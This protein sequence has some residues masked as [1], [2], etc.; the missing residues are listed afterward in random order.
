MTRPLQRGS[1]TSRALEN[2]W[3]HNENPLMF[4]T[5]G[6]EAGNCEGHGKTSVLV[7]CSIQ[8]LTHKQPQKG[9]ENGFRNSSR[10]QER[11]ATAVLCTLKSIFRSY[12][13]DQSLFSHFSDISFLR[14]RASNPI[15]SLCFSSPI[16]NKRGLS[17]SFGKISMVAFVSIFVLI[18]VLGSSSG[19]YSANTGPILPYVSY[20]RFQQALSRD[21]S[22]DGI[23]GV[24]TLQPKELMACSKDMEHHVP[25]Y[26]VSCARKAGLKAGEEF[27]RHCELSG[28]RKQC[29]IRPPKDYRLPVRWPHSKAAIWGGNVKVARDH[30]LA[31][32]SRR[33]RLMLGE[34]NMISFQ[35]QD[36]EAHFQQIAAIIGVQND[37]SFSRTGIKAVLD[38][39]CSFG[40]FITYLLSKN[41]LALCIAPYEAHNSQVQL[42][43]ERGLPAMIGSVI[44][45]QLPYPVSSFNM[46]QCAEC[47][48]NWSQKD[49]LL[50]MEIDRL[51]SQ[52]G[53]FVWSPPKRIEGKSLRSIDSEVQWKSIDEAA[54]NMCWTSFPKQDQVFVWRKAADR[55]CYETRAMDAMSNI[56]N[57]DKDSSLVAY[58]PLRPCLV[59]SLNGGL[60]SAEQQTFRPDIPLS[61]YGGFSTEELADDAGIWSS[62]V[63]NYWSLITPLIFSDHPKRPAEDDPLP[64]Y[65]I[66]RNVMDMNA[67]YGGF[68][69]AL[70]Q[71]GKSAW[72]MNV[73]PTTGRNT[74][75]IIYKRGFVGALHNWCEAFPTYPR[76][77]DLLHGVGLISQQV[78]TGCSLSNLFLEMDRILRP[79]GWVLLR[80]NTDLIEE[81]RVAASQMRWEARVTEV[82]GDSDLRLLV[83]QKI[84][85]KP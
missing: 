51:L 70:L 36:A 28:G 23:F 8:V 10:I 7:P 69:A 15:P 20:R 73:V 49:G 76:T 25:C 24:D 53:Y 44:T 66:L 46:I 4:Q 65:N 50:L 81:A 42:A 39:G 67:L 35:P 31:K 11:N 19:S 17:L 63:R 13:G 48:V 72:V 27:D 79:E 56:C 61:P 29:L 59:T 14:F 83:C 1:L 78:E 55:T 5:K 52:D 2:G 62:T 12:Q 85:W 16:S 71:A 22:V 64:P 34:N 38:M 26:N 40:S 43:L 9:A 75:P 60:L 6:E 18:A 21:F 47:G 33:E 54:K 57:D 37:S 32:D 3:S 80:D 82:E 30:L 74:L 58:G 41:L 77:Y 84:F 45:K 68:N